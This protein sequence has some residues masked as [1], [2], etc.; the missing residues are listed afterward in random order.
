MNQDAYC[1]L[2]VN[3]TVLFYFHMT[4]LVNWMAYRLNA[5]FYFLIFCNI[6]EHAVL[7]VSHQFLVS[8]QIFY[9]ILILFQS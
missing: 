3:D 2:E 6:L 8:Y 4:F 1:N 9:Y 7:I 5:T